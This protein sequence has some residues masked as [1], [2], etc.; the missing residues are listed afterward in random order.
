[1]GLT[2]ES[3]AATAF[4]SAV[5]VVCVFVFSVVCVTVC[6]RQCVCARTCACEEVSVSVQVSV[7]NH[8]VGG[9]SLIHI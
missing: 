4:S 2:G 9:L 8:I 5:C 6:V 1:M 3:A 7:C